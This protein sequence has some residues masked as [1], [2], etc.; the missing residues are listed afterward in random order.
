MVVDAPFPRT[1]LRMFLK[2]NLVIQEFLEGKRKSYYAPVKYLVLCFF[3]N[4]L[5]TKAVDFDPIEIQKKIEHRE[6]E[7][8]QNMGY[9]IGSFISKNLNY[10]LFILPF[11]ISFFSKLWFWKYSYNFAE[12][13]VIGFYLSAQYIILAIIPILLV[14]IHP[15]LFYSNYLISIVYITYGL[16]KIFKR[17]SFIKSIIKAYFAALMSL[18]IYILIA[19]VIAYIIITSR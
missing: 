16:Y 8:G 11:T 13:T 9:E 14:M 10:F 15:V 19:V 6:A 4:F 18:V 7:V 3:I 5:V 17:K 1:F 2:P 12:R